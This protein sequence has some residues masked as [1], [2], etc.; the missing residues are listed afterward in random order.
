MKKIIL[1]FFAVL[2]ITGCTPPKE[3]IDVAKEEEAIQALIEKELALFLDRDYISQSDLLVKED[4]YMGVSTYGNFHNQTIGWDSVFVGLKKASE[5][6][7]PDVT[8]HNFECKDFHIKVYDK[9][10]WAV[11]NTLETADFKGEPVNQTQIRVTFLE[12]VDDD[13]KIALYSMT[14]LNPCK[15]DDEGDD[16]DDDNDDD[17]D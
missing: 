12:K 15:T 8:N 16:E 3:E 14:L 17:D 6:D 5:R 2:L 11:F 1:A 13:W 9:V 7:W 10:A 4:Y